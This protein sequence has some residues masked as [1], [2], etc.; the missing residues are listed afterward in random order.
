MKKDNRRKWIVHICFFMV[1]MVLTFWSVFRNQDFAGMAA[2]VR[3]LSVPSAMKA[4]FLAVAFVAGEG[5]MIWY[6]LKGIGEKTNLRRCISYSFIGFFFSSITPSA[7]G[8]QPM[9]LY[10]MKKDGN[11]LSSASVVLMTVA[12]MYKF[13]LAL[14]GIGILL[15]GRRTLLN[16]FQGYGWLYLFGLLLNIAVVTVLILVMFS[17][18]IIRAV[19]FKTEKLLIHFRLWKKSEQR[20]NKME[21]FLS[22]Y[23]DT[24]CFLRKHKKMIV[25]VAIG[26]FVQR[27]SAFL[28]TYVIYR[29]LGLHGFSMWDIVWLQASVYIAV[30][31]LPVPGAQG[32]TEA[33]FQNVFQS[34][35]TEQY[36]VASICITRGISFYLVMLLGLGVFVSYFWQTKKDSRLKA[37]N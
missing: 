14:T 36:L 29:G 4:V 30:D 11:S 5:C 10:Y 9:Q 37:R 19:S 26:T 3:K 16:Y 27:F 32:I 34:I 6:L 2:S 31:M 7:T 15:L 24:V 25:V 1:V 13:V 8:G 20:K 23:Q 21:Q 18:G 33:M 12:V 22:G 17:P 28:L 35:F